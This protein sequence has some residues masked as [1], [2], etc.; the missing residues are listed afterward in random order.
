MRLDWAPAAFA[1]SC[2]ERME[3]F[4]Y[5]R[6]AVERIAPHDV[7]HII[8]SVTSS[9]DD[10][11][12]LSPGAHCL[13]VVRLSFADQ[14]AASPDHPERVVFSRDHARAIWA[15]IVAHRER[16]VRLVVHCDAGVSRSPAIA[17]GIARALG[18]D[19]GRFF[20]RYA[21]NTLVYRTV[22]ETFHDEFSMRFGRGP[23]GARPGRPISNLE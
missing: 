17:A 19:D 15:A 21:P 11:A 13:E 23:G 4:V 20:K 18:E 16:L 2:A 14:D 12:R 22:I 7:G 5:S 3:F 6:G 10:Q 1:L 9:L 8:I